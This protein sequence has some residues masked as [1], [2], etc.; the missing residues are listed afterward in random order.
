MTVCAGFLQGFLLS[1]KEAW[2]SQGHRM[3]ACLAGG[4]A[5]RQINY[6]YSVFHLD[7]QELSRL[8]KL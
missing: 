7:S 3:A 1:R 2:I 4:P 8:L 6:S 5:R